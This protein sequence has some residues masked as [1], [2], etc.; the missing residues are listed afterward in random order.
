MNDV[1]NDAMKDAKVT[2]V[3]YDLLD[4]DCAE[5]VS[6]FPAD[7]EDAH[8]LLKYSGLLGDMRMAWTSCHLDAGLLGSHKKVTLATR[9]VG[10][11]TKVSFRPFD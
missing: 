5:H 4:D 11:R 9:I 8:K 10:G 6:W 7:G 2:M 1:V 3:T